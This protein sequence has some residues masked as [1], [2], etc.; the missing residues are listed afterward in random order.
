MPEISDKELLGIPTIRETNLNGRYGFRL[1]KRGKVRDVYEC[2]GS[3]VLYLVATDRI[4][5]F[6]AV[7]PK[8]IP[9]K[10]RC[11]TGM[12]VYSFVSS[13]DIVPNHFLDSPDPNVTVV[14]RVDERYPIELI[15]RGFIAGSLWKRYAKGEREM[16]GY[17]F[18]GGL[19]ENEELPEPIVTP[20][21]KADVGHDVPLDSDDAV[22][23]LI[24]KAMSMT[25]GEASGDWRR[26][27]RIGVA[28]Y[29]HGDS[30]AKA[31]GAR[32]IDTKYEMGKHEG[33]ICVIDEM[34]TPD[35]SR[36]VEQQGYAERFASGEAQ[37]WL[38]KQVTRD[39]LEKEAKWTGDGPMPEYPDSI[40]A[41]TA[42]VY[43]A[44]FRYVTG[45]DMP[46]L[47]EPPSDE[48]ILRALT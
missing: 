18:P 21:T 1:V 8:D 6:D 42:R 14:Q 31:N 34:H 48:R 23:Q 30:C 20:T 37:Q 17:G 13:R 39:Y 4:S 2:D 25:P 19:R 9:D 22:V 15:V 28:L 32:L 41:A 38:D 10:G 5:A 12:S 40:V 29:R 24:A 36:F 44:C 46:P 47:S 33:R 27:K 45:K 3:D 7:L 16:Y 43:R 26:L 35:S 11:L